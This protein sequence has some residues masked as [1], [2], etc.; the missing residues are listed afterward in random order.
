MNDEITNQANQTAGS[1][2]A[3]DESGKKKILLVED[4]KMI[5]SMY[6][7][8]LEADGYLVLTADNGH[9]GLELAL[10]ENPDLIMLDVILPQLDGFSVLQ[11]IRNNGENLR[12]K[13]VILLTNLA[14]FEDQEKGKAL[15]ANDYLVKSNL[16]PTQVSEKIKEH[17]AGI[18]E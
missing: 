13:P 16:T 11:E 17:L 6:K 2:P 14:T 9:Q 5:N 12:N 4:D 1:G 15:G 7:T 8:K 18:K 3:Q 10:N